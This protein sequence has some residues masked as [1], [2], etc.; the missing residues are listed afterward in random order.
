MLINPLWT[1][2]NKIGIILALWL[3][4]QCT[5]CFEGSWNGF[6]WLKEHCWSVVKWCGKTSVLAYCMIYTVYTVLYSYETIFPRITLNIVHYQEQKIEM[7]YDAATII[8]LLLY[9]Y[10]HYC[11]C[12]IVYFDFLPILRYCTYSAVHCIILYH[13]GHYHVLYVTK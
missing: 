3:G 5:L 9:Y 7:K 8:I 2:I 10:Y 1:V 11:D 6:D 13:T 4:P 12:N